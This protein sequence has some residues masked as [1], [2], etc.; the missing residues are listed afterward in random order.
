[1]AAQIWP[2]LSSALYYILLF[3]GG[4]V[5]LV[6]TLASLVAVHQEIKIWMPTALPSLSFYGC[7]KVFAFNMVWMVVCF[8]GCA[9]VLLRH[10]ITLGRTDVELEVNRLVEDWVA[11]V[12]IRAFVG[13]VRVV[14]RENLPERDDQT[15]APVFCCNHS[16][17]IDAA[18]VYYV[19]RRFKWVAKGSVVFL[20]G[21]GQVSPQLGGTTAKLSA[22]T[23][24]NV[25][26]FGAHVLLL[27]GVFYQVM[28]LGGHVLINRT[29]GRNKAS[30][31]AL[32]AK[33]N[34]AVQSGIPMFFFPQGTRRIDA[35]LDFKD[36]A[37]VVAQSNRS[38]IVPLSLDIPRNVWNHWYP[39]SRDTPVVT[40]TIH[41]PIHVT[42]EEDRA[43][44]KKQ[45]MDQIYSVLPL[46]PPAPREESVKE[47]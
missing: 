21:V 11:R 4:Y 31:S 37:F 17:Q 23:A 9:L 30:V 28:W 6:S 35:K 5:T 7:L 25:S 39:L 42:G 14:G 15:P 1:M 24:P 38:S 41:K 26:H 33:S 10:A 27:H 36:G 44:L 29:K 19:D 18:A 16:S 34:E 45:C 40:L 32:F 2:I 8:V 47:K 43:S 3:A 20:P 22:T 13:D 12:M 46:I